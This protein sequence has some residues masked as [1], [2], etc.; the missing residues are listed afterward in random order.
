MT[1]AIDAQR[2]ASASHAFMG[3]TPQG[4]AAIVRTR[5]N[6]DTHVILRGG[7]GGPNYDKA[8][9]DEAAKKIKAARKKDGETGEG[10]AAV[11]VDCSRKP[12]PSS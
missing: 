12:C 1:V 8:H 5:G 11:M 7:S 9:V 4:L 6:T 10:W 2:A 3:V